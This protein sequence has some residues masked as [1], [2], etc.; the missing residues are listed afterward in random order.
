MARLVLWMFRVLASCLPLLSTAHIFDLSHLEWTLKNHNSSIVVPG[1]LPSQAHLDLFK[2][3][4]INDPLLGINGKLRSCEA[5]SHLLIVAE[6][7]ERWVAND[8]WTYTADLTPFIQEYKE[9]ASGKTLLIFYGIDTIANIVCRI[10]HLF[11]LYSC[12]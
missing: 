1:S 8:N 10:I 5:L 11:P 3:G 12:C 9:E 7:T 6:L 2:A 4:V